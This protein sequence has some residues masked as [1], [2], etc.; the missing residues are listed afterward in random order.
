[1]HQALSPLNAFSSVVLFLLYVTSTHAQEYVFGGG[2]QENVSITTSDSQSD[3]TKTVSST[4]YLPNHNRSSRFLS[5]ATIG[6]NYDDIE[7]VNSMGIE[8]W[9]NEQINLPVS[10]PLESAVIDYHQ[11]VRDSLLAREN[12]LPENVSASIRYWEY[13]WWQYHMSQPDLLRQRTALA[14]SEIIVISTK[15]GFSNEPYAFSSFYDIFM[16]H[17]FGNFRDILQEVTYHPAMGSYLTYLANPK[18]DPDNNIFPDENYARE[19]MQLFTIGL[20]SLH[21]NGQ[22]VYQIN[23]ID[24]SKVATYDNETILEFS[25]IFTGLQFGDRELTSSQFKRTNA[26]NDTSW[27]VPMI[28]NNDYHEPGIKYLFNNTPVGSNSVVDG[29]QDI[30]EA[31]DNLFAHPNV[32][33]FICKLLIQRIV[34]SNPEPEY[35]ERVA[36]VFNDNGQG[37]K[38]DLA[39]TI[40]A[41]L[42]DPAALS[43]SQSEDVT[44]GMMR[45]PFIRYVHLSK[46]FNLQTS[47]GKHRNT[48]ESVYNYVEQK[49]MNSPS[50]F[51]FFQQFYQP[52][53]PLEDEQL[54]APE[55][56]ITNSQTI[57]GYLNGLNDWMVRNDPADEKGLFSGESIPDNERAF[58]DLSIELSLADDDDELHILVDRLDMLLAHG[59]LSDE[60]KNLIV[61]ALKEFPTD[62]ERDIDERARIA[63]Y[64]VLS[65]PEYLINR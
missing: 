56:Q 50:V 18:S 2:N 63:I 55:F 21:L 52:I 22:P 12:I 5:Q 43:C 49:P 32:G 53:G 45:E 9:L 58:Y 3:G 25:K 46:A 1:M 28:M 60:S 23:G 48:M 59:L 13:A 37:I 20:D 24:T 64:L 62:D 11:F 6:Y 29:N 31:L 40:K 16:R 39:A 61:E 36:N 10:Y 4:G 30:T 65:S 17:A 42:L 33:P 47:S 14:L 38:G 8:D 57:V 7:N 51:N 54:Y 27:A 44:F 34:T 41:I 26:R 19:V 35:V 15:S